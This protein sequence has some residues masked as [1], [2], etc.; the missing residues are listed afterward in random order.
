MPTLIEPKLAQLTSWL[1]TGPASPLARNSIWAMMG[2]GLRL[3]IQA[4]YFIIIARCLG[5]AEYGAFISVT[6]LAAVASPF[7]GLGTGNLLVKNVARNHRLF[8]E[9]W[10][11]GLLITLASGS[12]LLGVVIGLCFVILPRSIPTFAIVLVCISDLLFVKFVDISAWAFQGFEML[13]KNAQLNILIGLTRLAGIAALAIAARHA[14]VTMWAAVY[15]GGS[16]LAAIIG[17]TWATWQLGIPKLALH[18]VR[19]ES[20]EGFYFSFSLSALSIYND[21]D[22]TMVARLATLE[23]AGIYA[24]AYRLIDVAFIPVRSVLIAAYPGFFRQGADGLQASLHYGRRLLRRVLP[25]SLLAFF[26]LVFMAPLVPYV[27][28]HRFAQATEALRWLALLP[29]LKTLHYFVA[30]ALTGAGYQGL[31]TAMQAGVAVFN[32]LINLWL[33]PAYGW[34]GAAWSSLAS[35][36]MLAAGLWMLAS[37]LKRRNCV[38]STS[39]GDLVTS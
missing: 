37:F 26:A 38:I 31:R 24:A 2:Y 11:N 30:D 36:G 33:I 19:G 6:A 14:T 25:Y 3:L 29:L 5:P 21:I 28:G 7:V 23:A 17:V 34:R 1:P 4:V 35:D 9:Y 39:E 8:P 15:L 27:L 16:V 22:K 12:G 20:A 32:V 13:D 18:R 10:G